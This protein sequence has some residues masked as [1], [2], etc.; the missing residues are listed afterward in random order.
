MIEPQNHKKLENHDLD[1]E[2]I[3]AGLN[4]N[5]H[6]SEIVLDNLEQFGLTDIQ[7]DF[8]KTYTPEKSLI[9]YGTLAPNRA[10]HW[11]IEHINGRWQKAVVRGKLENKGWGAEFGYYAF[12]HTSVEEQ[13]EMKAIVFSS[14]HLVANWK[15]IDD[16]EGDGY[17]RILAKYD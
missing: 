16:F 6:V 11:V 10:N 1:I 5:R 13:E 17:R 9:I 15:H 12:R 4:K 7:K 2:T 3:I 14:G 8:I